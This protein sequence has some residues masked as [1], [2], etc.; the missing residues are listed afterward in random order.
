[1]PRKKLSINSPSII[2]DEK[3]KTLEEKILDIVKVSI[4]EYLGNLTGE[5][6]KR[7][8]LPVVEELVREEFRTKISPAVVSNI[9]SAVA[10]QVAASF[11]IIIASG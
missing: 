9:K 6:L 11:K 7:I 1:M 8:I 2:S 5:E 4:R 10:E 3:P